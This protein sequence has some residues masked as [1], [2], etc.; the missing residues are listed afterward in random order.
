MI[1]NYSIIYTYTAKK[2]IKSTLSYISIKL[3]NPVAAAK[4]QSLINEAINKISKFP[5][6]F[7]DCSIFFIND[8]NIR[9]II[10][11]NYLLIYKINNIKKEIY[12]LKFSYSK[13]KINNIYSPITN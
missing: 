8:K 10:I 2:S 1:N 7:P 6:A 3:F 5:F 12:I 13:V 9:H 11:N 4:L